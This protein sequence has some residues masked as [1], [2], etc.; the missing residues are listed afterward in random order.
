M[1]T[2]TRWMLL[3]LLPLLAGA[4][5]PREKSATP[6]GIV[7]FPLDE[8]FR[9]KEQARKEEAETLGKL[10]IV[11]P[12]MLQ[13]LSKG[14]SDH[15]SEVRRTSAATLGRFGQYAQATAI[16]LQVAA[17]GDPEAKVRNAACA[18]RSWS[19]AAN[20]LFAAPNCSR[21]PVVMPARA[22][23]SASL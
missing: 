20:A 23:A 22:A 17:L 6:D 2:R 8:I 9:A 5:E 15:D 21:T 13:T 7:E 11:N 12:A 4:E 14:L 10:R 1:R 18:A 16:D 3:L 19:P